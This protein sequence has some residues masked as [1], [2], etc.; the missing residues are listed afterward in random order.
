MPNYNDRRYYSEHMRREADDLM[1]RH[2]LNGT[3]MPHVAWLMETAD[4][5][6]RM[7]DRRGYEH[8]D[9]SP[10]MRR[11]RTRM[12]YEDGEIDMRRG[13]AMHRDSRGRF[14]SEY[15]DGTHMMIGQPTHMNAMPSYYPNRPYMHQSGEEYSGGKIGFA[16]GAGKQ[17]MDR[18][19]EDMEKVPEYY[20]AYLKHK[21]LYE[22]TKDPAEKQH[23]L[24]EMQKLTEYMGEILKE[25]HKKATTPEEKQYMQQMA[26]KMT[27]P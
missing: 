4:R 6:D 16:S 23:M 3:T 20:E 22:Q 15:D 19:G 7:N 17:R 27:Q 2:G 9:E 12:E 25:M 18:I 24:L 11:G 1:T 10:E 26:Q 14:T 13:G 5:Y 21:H 8:D